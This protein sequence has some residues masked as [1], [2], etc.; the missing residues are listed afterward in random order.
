MRAGQ[1]VEPRAV[2]VEG[3]QHRDATGLGL[4]QG[5]MGA[6]HVVVGEAAACEALADQ[7][8][9]AFSLRLGFFGDSPRF[10]GAG[11]KLHLKAGDF[12]LALKAQGVTT[13]VNLRPR[14]EMADHGE[15]A[16]VA[17]KAASMLAAIGPEGG[18]R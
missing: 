10:I 6:H 15:A 18:D 8:D 17:A 9:G 1:A 4:Q 5:R 13:I 16:E 7:D 3:L 2:V 12:P 14:A 11:Q